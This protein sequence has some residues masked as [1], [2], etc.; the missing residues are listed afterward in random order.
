MAAAD[1]LQRLEQEFYIIGDHLQEVSSQVL[2]ENV[3]K[4]PIF[5]V[6]L[7]SELHLGIPVLNSSDLGLRFFYRASILEELV[8][9][10]VVSR[11]KLPEFKAAFKNPE[12][13]ACLF[14]VMPDQPSVV[15][16]PYDSAW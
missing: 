6:G 1:F 5:I 16:V 2:R 13:F 15:F 4:Y 8:K 12:E 9:K 10:E 11:E 7:Q 14:L 3:S